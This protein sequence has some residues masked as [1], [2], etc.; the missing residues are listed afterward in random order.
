VGSHEGQ[1]QWNVKR[2]YQIPGS[3]VDST[4]VQISVRVIDYQGGGGMYGDPAIMRLHPEQ[5]GDT[6]SLAGDWKYVPVAELM[7][8]A[9]FVF[10]PRGN[11]Y[12][13]RPR[14]AIDLSANTPTTL[15][16]GMIAPVIP[17]S[18]RGAIWYQGESNAERARQYH[19]LFPLLIENWRADFA[20]GDFPFYFVQIAPFDYGTATQS[21][22]LREAQAAAL[23]VKNTGM[24]VTLDIGNA[25]N[26]H[27]ANKKDVGQR[28]A[29]WALAKT[30]GHR[31]EYSGPIYKSNKKRKGSIEL[32]FAHAEKGLVLKEGSTGNS[33]QIAGMDRVFKNAVVKVHG[34][35]LVVSNPEIPQPV[36]VRYAF[37]NTPEA[38]LFNK[39]G[40]PAPS[41]RTDDWE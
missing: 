37:S 36:T 8:N 41:F 40:L 20:V 39:D 10:G 16:N 38:T 14:F 30:Y 2:V 35:T 34:R 26:I 25:K 22:Y 15:Y 21:Q 33:F 13:S 32:F 4:I 1:G 3:I 6:I 29:L 11:Q 9:L 7:G 18:I 27:P 31:V 12:E 19:S 17:F 23:S 28:L 5:S 24:A